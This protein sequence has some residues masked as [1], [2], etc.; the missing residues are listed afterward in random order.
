MNLSESRAKSLQ[1]PKKMN[2]YVVDDEFTPQKIG[3]IVR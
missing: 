1:R 2:E 3:K